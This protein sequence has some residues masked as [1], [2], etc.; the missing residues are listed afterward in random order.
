VHGTSTCSHLVVHVE[1]LDVAP[2]A[3]NDINQV[4]HSAVLLE[5]QLQQHV[6]SGSGGGVAALRNVDYWQLLA[7]GFGGSATKTLKKLKAVTN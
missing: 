5:Q 6:Q 3:L 4:I 1:A 2:V 7:E